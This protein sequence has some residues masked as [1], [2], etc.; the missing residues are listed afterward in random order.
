MVE[1][2]LSKR[3]GEHTVKRAS[4]VSRVVQ[5]LIAVA[6][7]SALSGVSPVGA[8]A[9]AG[10]AETYTQTIDA[11]HSLN[12]VSCVPATTT[13]IAAD[14]NGNLF[15]ATDVSVSSTA[16]WNSWSGP[17]VSPS[18]AVE[19][20]SATLCLLAAGEVSGGGGNLYRASSLGGSFLTSF[21]PSNGVGALSCPSTSFCVSGQEGNGFIRYS[22]NPSGILW[23]AVQIGTGAMKGVSCLSSSFC[24]VVDDSGNVHVATT[25]EHIKEAG[26]AGWTDTDV[27]DATA[28]RGIACS[29]TTSCIAVDGSDEVLNLTIGSGGEA[30]VSR[31]SIDGANELTAVSCAGSTC[32]A[33]D[34]Q[35]GIF[36]STNAGADW[37]VRYEGAPVTSVS[38]ASASLCSAV[39]TTGDV[40]MF[41]P[42]NTT[43][44]LMITSSALP[45]GVVGTPYEA[46]VHA[47]GG[48]PPYEWSATGLPPGLSIDST[49]GEISGTPENVL[50]VG[51]PCHYTVMLMV[52]DSND[53]E[54]SMSLTITLA[55]NAYALKVT[56][57]GAGSGA[58]NSSPAGI[59][60]CGAVAGSCEAPYE[61][62]TVVTLTAKPAADSTFAGWSGGGCSGTAT[63]QVTMSAETE[64][65]ATFSKVSPSP[66]GAHTLAIKLVGAGKGRVEDATGAIFCP[67]TCSHA[68]VAGT[69]VTLAATPAPGSRFAGWSEGGCSGRGVCQLT[70]GADTTLTARFT[71]APRSSHSRVLVSYRQEGGIGGPRPSLVVFKDRRA[72]V[73]L[74]GCTAKFSLRPVAWRRLRAALRGAHLHAI[75]GDYPAP[76]GSADMITYVIKA[77]GEVVRIAPPQPE[78]EDVMRNLRPLLKVLNRTVSA[79]E[80]RMPSSCKSNSARATRSW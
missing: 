55:V 61:D 70:I 57:G 58:L 71:K 18:H 32:A 80:R 3:R 7:V 6:A 54:A 11:G 4:R 39:T 20:P 14:S 9:S 37:L 28:L 13:C 68:Y 69:L 72:R 10:Y 21:T 41:N 64:V 42:A 1:S 59:D 27:N 73:R 49:S 47:T 31:Q 77:S 60:E 15:Y 74:G 38:C 34:E 30:T 19:C 35:G 48:E 22:T 78:H 5:C 29:S 76:K 62:G 50:C 24:A 45:A 36:A 40:T 17:G 44:P 33:A 46:E 25:E 65:T 63:C 56:A 2:Q 53:T 12:A 75:A 66:P 67:S 51:E 23:T 26:G 8:A 43:P 52:T 79:G 16:T